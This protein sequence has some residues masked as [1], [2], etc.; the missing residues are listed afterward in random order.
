MHQKDATV[1]KK[2]HVTQVLSDAEARKKWGGQISYKKGNGRSE[3]G[4]AEE[5][6]G[7]MRP[8]SSIL[9]VA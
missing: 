5:E 4:P 6:A 3:Q 8:L 9:E 1:T 7:R 2:N